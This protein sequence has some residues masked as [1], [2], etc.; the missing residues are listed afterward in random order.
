MA[1]RLRPIRRRERVKKNK[2]AKGF[3]HSLL[4]IHSGGRIGKNTST[5][6]NQVK[7]QRKEKRESTW[8]YFK[9]LL[10]PPKY[11]RDSSKGKQERGSIEF[12][13]IK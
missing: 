4:E 11:I 10:E 9:P 1:I 6:H 13:K 8:T 2:R 3:T 5:E 7:G 12:Q